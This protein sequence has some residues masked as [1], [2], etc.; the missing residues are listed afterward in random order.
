[1]FNSWANFREHVESQHELRD[2]EDAAP[3]CPQCERGFANAA[4]V[5]RHI[6]LRQCR[7][8]VRPPSPF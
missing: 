7:A 2:I 3:R 8:V 5:R 6:R 1:M 4:N